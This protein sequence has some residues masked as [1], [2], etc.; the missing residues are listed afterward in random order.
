MNDSDTCE[1]C[2]Y[3]MEGEVNE[4][5]QRKLVCSRFPPS[6]VGAATPQ[7]LVITSVHPNVDPGTPACGE[8]ETKLVTVN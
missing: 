7:G 8:F 6:P 2:T 3:S 5:L 4:S 1:H